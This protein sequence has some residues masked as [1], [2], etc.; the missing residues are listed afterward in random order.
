MFKQINNKLSVDSLLTIILILF[1]IDFY[2]Q[3]ILI[4]IVGAMYYLFVKGIKTMEFSP[5]LLGFVVF[6]ISF[7][8]FSDY[9]EM[10]IIK[11]VIALPI[12]FS[13]GSSIVHL[14]QKE[15]SYSLLICAFTMAFHAI[16]NMFYNFKLYG[17]AAMGLRNSSDFWT[18]EV[19]L[20]TGQ[21]AKMTPFLSCIFVLLFYNKNNKLKLLSILMFLSL[22]IYN[23]SLGGR[24]VIVITILSVLITLFLAIKKEHS[25]RITRKLVPII[26]LIAFVGIYAYSSNIFNVQEL[27][28][29]SSFNQ[30]FNTVGGQDIQD[31]NRMARKVLYI[32]NLFK[33]P[34]GG[35]HLC[36]DEKIGHAH[37]LWLDCF[38]MVGLIPF[39]LICL[40][41]VKSMSRAFKYYK[42]PNMEPYN[43]V[44][45]L[46]FFIIM[47]IQFFLEPI[48]EGSPKLLILCCFVDGQIF[49][50]LK[51]NKKNRCHCERLLKTT[52]DYSRLYC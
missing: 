29:E 2:L 38:D 43:G 6:F 23:F 42:L 18:G 37:D 46:S 13:F 26:G 44:A 27:F 33:Y 39:I 36:F 35:Q 21:A 4:F 14:S 47:N 30:R 40:Y 11:T 17:I 31:D 50:Y 7:Y 12:A 34:F 22:I 32:E 25:F 15:I 41:S 16:L 45:V 52:S 8:M 5:L 20:S 19:S 10:S 1:S 3:G 49:K 9:F 48:I 51:N 24:S 28:E